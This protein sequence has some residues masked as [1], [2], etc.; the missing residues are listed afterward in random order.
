[1]T[2]VVVAGRRT[3]WAQQHDALTLKPVSGRNFE[4]AALSAGESSDVLVYLMSLP[5]P[6]PAVVAAVDAGVA[7]LEAHAIRGKAWTGGRN[8]PPGPG[9]PAGGRYLAAAA[10][11]APLIWPRYTSIETGRPVF[12]DRDKTIHDD[13]AELTLERR[14]GYA[15]YSSGAQAA[16]DAF[17]AWKTAH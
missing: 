16:L 9:N 12:G 11:D 17:A 14:N 1:M 10:P 8:T 5:H 6:S 2:Q 3:V 13:V 4:P 7:W 15:W